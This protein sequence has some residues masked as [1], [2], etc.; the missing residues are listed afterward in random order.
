M[1]FFLYCPV[2]WVQM[3]E[4]QLSFGLFVVGFK[5]LVFKSVGIIV[6]GSDFRRV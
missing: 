2:N 4:G 1:L 5:C 3:T 6:V